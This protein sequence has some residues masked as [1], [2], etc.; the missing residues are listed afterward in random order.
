M[1]V[2]MALLFPGITNI[3]N[4]S[5]RCGLLFGLTLLYFIFLLAHIRVHL[6]DVAFD[7]SLVSR[8][9]LVGDKGNGRNHSLGGY[10]CLCT[11]VVPDHLAQQPD[12]D[13]GSHCGAVGGLV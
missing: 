6:K 13:E 12:Y 7:L 2:I 8:L 3:R 11:S 10:H 9:H 5:L 4:P 1:T